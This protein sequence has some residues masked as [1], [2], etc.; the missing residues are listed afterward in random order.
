MRMGF[1][2]GWGANDSANFSANDFASSFSLA[3]NPGLRLRSAIFASVVTLM[4]HPSLVA[5]SVSYTRDIAQRM[6]F[7]GIA[8][9]LKY[10]SLTSL[11]SE[12][13]AYASA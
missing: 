10:D 8:A 2:W 13:F 7:S 1:N 12:R 6:T 5:K 11:A 4:G 9:T 3:P